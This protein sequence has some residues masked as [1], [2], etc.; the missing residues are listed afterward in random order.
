MRREFKV[1]LGLTLL[2]AIF[3]FV[4]FNLTS[5]IR[6]ILISNNLNIVVLILTLVLSIIASFIL[7]IIL[8][9]I[10]KIGNKK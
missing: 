4:L 8:L 7:Y 1:Y 10:T 6:I 5:L 3:I 2:N 9:I